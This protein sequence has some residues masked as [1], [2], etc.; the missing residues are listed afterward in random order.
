MVDSPLVMAYM[1]DT[2]YEQYIREFLIRSGI[3]KIGELQNRSLDY[4]S[5]R[6]QRRHL[7]RLMDANFLTEEEME[8]V[9]WG[10]N[11]KGAKTKRADIG[12]YRLATGLETLIGKLYFS[13]KN[14]RI[15]EIMNFIIG[16]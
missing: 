8:I 14:D 13:N 11:A 7:E 6:S 5:A 1:G 12:T 10:R 16:E 15:K 4:V 2:I 3:S 9:K